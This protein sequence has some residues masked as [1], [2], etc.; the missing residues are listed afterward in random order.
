M[1]YQEEYKFEFLKN[2]SGTFEKFKKWYT[3]VRNQ[4]ETI[5]KALRTE[6]WLEVCFKSI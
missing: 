1:I 4:I 3:L 2:K 5:L 6:K